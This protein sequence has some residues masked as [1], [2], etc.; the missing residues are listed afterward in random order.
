MVYQ[1]KGMEE[2]AILQTAARMCAA[3]PT[4]PQAHGRDTIHTLVLTGVDK[5]Q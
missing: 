4:A 5:D 3:A 1:N 2:Q